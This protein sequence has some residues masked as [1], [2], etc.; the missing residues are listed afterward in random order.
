MDNLTISKAAERFALLD[1]SPI[2]HFVLN[3]DFTVLFWNKCLEAWT[4]IPRGQ[5]VG[6]SISARFPHLAEEKYVSRIKSTFGGGPPTIFS[7]QLHKQIIPAPLPGGKLRFQYTVVTALPEPADNSYHALFSIQDVTSLT[8]AIDNNRVVL[9]KALAEMEERRKV[10]AELVKYT[11]E[12][13]RLNR[14]LKERSIRDGL[15]GLFN[16]RYFYYVLRRDFLLSN[17]NREDLACLLL[18]LDHFKE[19]NDNHGHPFGDKVLKNVAARIGR[20]VRETDVVSRYGG[21]EFAILLP[22][23]DLA[24]ALVAAEKIRSRIGNRP[25]GHDALDIRVTVSIGI[26]TCKEHRPPKPED[27]LAFADK[28]L[29]AAKAGGRNC[30]V[31]YSP[32]GGK[33]N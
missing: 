2:G 23:T 15:T 19:I 22:G 29:Y 26:A 3:R 20:I 7:S 16:H 25:F 5:I 9:Q 28:A 11:E 27:L 31:A 8:E 13:K 32:E 6:E 24:G 12:L 1:H 18:D 17:R 4:G 33:S 10:E 21:E 14:A 30:V